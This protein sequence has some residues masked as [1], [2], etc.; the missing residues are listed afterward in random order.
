MTNLLPSIQPADVADML[1]VSV[2]VYVLLRWIQTT[3]SRGLAIAA[4]A[5]VAVYVAAVEFG[6]HLTTLLFQFGLT[7]A[8]VVFVVVFQDDIRRAVER[9]LLA[10]HR[11][12]RNPEP[13]TEPYIESLLATAFDLAAERRGALIVVAGDESLDTHL[14]GGTELLGRI[15]Q[16]LLESL[17][18]PHSAGHDGAVIIENGFVTRFGVHL[19]LSDNRQK[20]QGLGT[21]HRSGLGLSECVDALVIIVSEERGQVSI[22]S[23]G[24]LRRNVSREE[25]TKSLAGH[26]AGVESDMRSGFLFRVLRHPRTKLLSLA[27]SIV[28]WLSVASNRDL[29][30]RVFIVP[31]EYRNVPAA[32]E[33]P[34]D[35]RTEARVTFSATERAFQFVA[36]SVLKVSI[37]VGEA[38]R[39]KE[40]FTLTESSVKHP[41]SLTVF[42]IEPRSIRLRD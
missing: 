22:A 7:V 40:V 14:D 26:L 29:V 42:R 8:V 16:P 1:V 31:I 6:L 20:S 12:D 34:D 10:T 27:I 35:I 5:S 36:P 37:D 30:Q 41:S 17:F 9:T 2:C 24:E 23:Q 15:S 3:V 13:A 39:G 33:L 18:D 21:R 4:G 11:R 38:D 32:F 28:T 25:L 19:P